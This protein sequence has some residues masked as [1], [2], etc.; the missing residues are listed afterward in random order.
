[1]V[2]F[3]FIHSCNS[4]AETMTRTIVTL[5][6]HQ[7]NVFD[8]ILYLL[9]IEASPPEVRREFKASVTPSPSSAKLEVHKEMTVPSYQETLNISSEK[10]DSTT[11]S[12]MLSA[13]SMIT[14][15]DV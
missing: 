2:A 11:G 8:I 4:H 13:T 1:M 12:T 3:L 5:N 14:S 6:Y 7:F 9:Y 15:V 10:Y